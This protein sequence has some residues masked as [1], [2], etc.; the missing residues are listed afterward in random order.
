MVGGCTFGV[1]HH[2]PQSL[3]SH[4]STGSIVE[5]QLVHSIKTILLES[6]QHAYSSGRGGW[7]ERAMVVRERYEY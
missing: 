6:V 5:H 1:V 3:L 4:P 7:I 2:E